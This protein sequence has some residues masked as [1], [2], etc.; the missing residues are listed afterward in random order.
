MESSVP[1]LR[2]DVHEDDANVGGSVFGNSAELA[3]VE[4]A[5][6]D[7]V[8]LESFGEDLGHE[9][10][11]CIEQSDWAEGLGN[12]VAIFLWFRYDAQVGD[13][14]VCGPDPFV[15]NEVID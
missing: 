6:R 4:E 3:W 14:E 13:L 15:Q 7:A 8:E 2:N 1:V 12:I 9:F 11:N 5:V 10:T